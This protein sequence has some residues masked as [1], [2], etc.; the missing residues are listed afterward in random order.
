MAIKKEN[1]EPVSQ[2]VEGII[3]NRAS[4]L[5][6]HTTH[7]SYTV[8]MAVPLVYMHASFAN[9][10]I[11]LTSSPINWL[12]NPFNQFYFFLQIY[13]FYSFSFIL[14]VGN[15]ASIWILHFL[16]VLKKI[17]KKLYIVT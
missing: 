14:K 17:H 13:I 9:S 11:T 8:P 12:E 10:L 2:L 1:A 7:T 4:G 3:F 6:H 16:C 15:I 5:Q